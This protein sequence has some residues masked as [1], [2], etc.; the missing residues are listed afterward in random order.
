MTHFST[1]KATYH[2]FLYN[3]ASYLKKM[4]RCILLLCAACLFP[5]SLATAQ[6]AGTPPGLRSLEMSDDAINMLYKLKSG[7][8]ATDGA[9]D[10]EPDNMADTPPEKIDQNTKG[11]PKDHKSTDGSPQK[12]SGPDPST[13]SHSLTFIPDDA[14][15]PPSDTSERPDSKDAKTDPKKESESKSSDTTAPN[16]DDK[17]F[18]R[19]AKLKPWD[20]RNI[21][22]GLGGNSDKIRENLIIFES[23]PEYAN[24]QILMDVAA[25]YAQVGDYK[26]AARYYYAANL[27]R[28]FD[29]ARF[30]SSNVPALDGGAWA[31]SVGAWV[32]ASSARMKNVMSDVRAWDERTPYRYHPGY[33]V[34]EK[35][36]NTNVPDESEWGDILTK[37]RTDFFKSVDEMSQALGRMGK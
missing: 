20:K 28:A 32:A 6:D 36:I 16:L 34:A 8:G 9:T 37:T 11:D 31:E 10:V 12:S 33:R 3:K 24:P 5:L 29:V 15:H 2:L 7:V 19:G 22:Y 4:N 25:L 35:S 23:E 21:L 13:Q 27:R 14:E 1:E 26:S 17:I 18:T 30:P